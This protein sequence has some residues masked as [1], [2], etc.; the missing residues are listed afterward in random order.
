MDNSIRS[1]N[2]INWCSTFFLVFNKMW[3]KKLHCSKLL[4]YKIFSSSPLESQITL[5]W[6]EFRAVCTEG[7]LF[8]TTYLVPA[9][10]LLHT[11]TDTTIY[12][13]QPNHHRMLRV[14]AKSTLLVK[15]CSRLVL[16]KPFIPRIYLY[17]Q[18]LLD[19]T[20]HRAIFLL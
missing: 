20:T 13:Q 8:H 2:S 19:A 14:F 15:K 5:F 16:K 3:F 17:T 4:Y 6:T 18:W 7:F 10:F 12:Y 9:T 1:F 11:H